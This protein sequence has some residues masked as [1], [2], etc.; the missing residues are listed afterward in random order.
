MGKFSRGTEKGPLR[1]CGGG[2]PDHISSGENQGEL[3]TNQPRLTLAHPSSGLHSSQETRLF[4][5]DAITTPSIR[6]LAAIS[7]ATLNDD[8]FGEDLSTTAF[9]H[10]IASICEVEAGA[11]VMSGTMAN[12]LALAALCHSPPHAILA[13]A[14]AHV[15]NFEA[16][17]IFH[18]TGAM[19]QPVRPQNGLYLTLEDIQK[20]AKLETDVPIEVCPTKVIS[21]ENTAHGSVVPLSELRA[22]KEWASRNGILVHVDG[23]RIWHAVAAEN[24]SLASIAS[25]TDAMTLSFAKGIGAPIGAM[26]VG[27]A[28]IVRRVKRLRQSIGGGVRKSGVLAAAAREAVMENFGPGGTDVMGTLQLVHSMAKKVSWMWTRRGGKLLRPTETNIVWLDLAAAGTSADVL[29]GMGVE[30]GILLA[31][32][33]IVLHHQI[34]ADALASLEH[35]FDMVLVRDQTSVKVGSRTVTKGCVQ[36]L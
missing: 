12:Q 3:R 36:A 2:V 4:S 22:I 29:G 33:R 31:A 7:R 5:A 30:K 13:D 26:I 35:I 8:V 9:E 20:H 1:L 25:C 10:H 21:L 11:F 23:A 19:V 32:P 6:Q 24:T 27:S 16:D 15:V 17:G 18:L 14:S 34:S 28:S